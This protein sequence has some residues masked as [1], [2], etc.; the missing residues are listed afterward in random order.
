MNT[1]QSLRL[2]YELY[3]KKWLPNLEL[4]QSYGLLAIK[5]WQ[6]HALRLDFLSPEKCQHLSQL[7]RKNTIIPIENISFHPDFEWKYKDLEKIPFAAA[8]VGQ[9]YKAKLL[10]DKNIV[11]KIVKSKFKK[12]FSYD[13]RKIRKFFTIILHFNPKLKSV[14]NPLWI[15]DDIEEYTLTELDLTNEIQGQKILQDIYNSYKDIFDLSA[16][17]FFQI[18]RE[19]SNEDILVSD[20][21][22]WK[23]LDELLSEGKFDYDEMLQF[24]YIQGFYIF[25]AGQFHGDIHPGNII[26]NDGKFYF[27]DSAYIGRV[28]DKIRVG[29]FHF[30]DALSNNDYKQCAYSLNSMSEN[31]IQGNEYDIFEQKFIALYKDYAGKTVSEIS[32]T[33]QM[34]LTIK[35]WVNSGMQFEKGIFSIIRSLMYLDGMVLKC[36]PNAVLMEDMKQF[37]EKYRKYIV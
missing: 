11:I 23:T 24:F 3:Y 20:F 17:W 10:N 18:Y 30:F 1:L 6:I 26:Y 19:Y 14:G 2:I 33:K 25:I 34:M 37:T 4:I 31:E 29:L 7:Y 9:V 5:I 16:L 8:S 21:V 22:E 35:L 32:L 28:G 36:N 27:I 12:Q 13:V 15:L